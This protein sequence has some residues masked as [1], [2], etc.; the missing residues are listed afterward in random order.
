MSVS[1]AAITV[2]L[3]ANLGIFSAMRALPNSFRAS[4]PDLQ[5][6][7]GACE[8]SQIHFL[9]R[10]AVA[11]HPA[12]RVPRRSVRQCRHGRQI[13]EVAQSED[14]R[15]DDAGGQFPYGGAALHKARL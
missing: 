14:A 13:G 15:D 2:L 1:P 11:V 12:L 3:P 9:P 6:C 10:V 8:P 7:R 5:K 4:Y